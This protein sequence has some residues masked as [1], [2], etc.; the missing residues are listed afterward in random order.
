M[1]LGHYLITRRWHLE[2]FLMEDELKWV[3]VWLWVPG[4][5]I[6]YYMKHILWR[7]GDCLG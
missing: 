4:L 2:F 6:E 3:A 7:I 1:V 5:P